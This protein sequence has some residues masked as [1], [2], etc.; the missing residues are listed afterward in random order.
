MYNA[1][2]GEGDVLT[3]V[4]PSV[5]QQGVSGWAGGIPLS[6]I[7][8]GECYSLHYLFTFLVPSV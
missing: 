1:V 8:T 6:C 4:C 2:I 3:C 7:H 5:C